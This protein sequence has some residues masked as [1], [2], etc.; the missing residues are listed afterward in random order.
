MVSI[1]PVYRDSNSLDGPQLDRPAVLD[2]ALQ[3]DD[4]IAAVAQYLLMSPSLVSRNGSAARW[5]S[6]DGAVALDGGL[7]LRI[8]NEFGEIISGRH[9]SSREDTVAPDRDRIM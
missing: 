1:R 8:A 4:A 5:A 6:V 2:L 7:E 3:P 9:R